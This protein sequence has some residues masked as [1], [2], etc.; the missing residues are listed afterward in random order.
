MTF[1]LLSLVLFAF[2]YPVWVVHRQ[3]L[4][5]H[6][7]VEKTPE[8]WPAPYD[9]ICFTTNEGILLKGWWVPAESRKAV[10]LLH[11]NGGSRNGYHSGVFE[12]GRRYHE[13]GFN[14]MMVDLRAHG[15]SGGK[16]IYF[17]VRESVDMLEWLKRFD[18][19]WRYRW[20]L[21]GF[22]MGAATVLMMAEYAPERFDFVAADAPWI[23]FPYLVRQELWKRSRL[24][25]FTYGYICWIAETFFGQN[26]TKADNRARC[27]KLCNR[28]VLYIFEGEDALIVP[29]HREILKKQCSEAK[30][31][32]FGKVGHVDAFKTSPERYMEMIE[33]VYL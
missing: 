27:K 6:E 18:S 23:D 29:Y 24:P 5:M 4:G 21:H 8:A 26:F 30:M 15:E 22:S 12:L 31:R 25:A 13:R 19:D 11:G 3:T 32:V 2:L 10:L 9:D 7:T 14:V 1:P 20:S 17:G 16:R 33:N 28:N